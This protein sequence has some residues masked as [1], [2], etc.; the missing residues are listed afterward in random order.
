MKRY[1]FTS[2]KYISFPWDTLYNISGVDLKS[3]QKF[4]EKF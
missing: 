3:L 4:A 2:E 1:V